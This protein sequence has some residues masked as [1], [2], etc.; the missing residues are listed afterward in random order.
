MNP[1]QGLALGSIPR[2]RRFFCPREK[3]ALF[4]STSRRAAIHKYIYFLPAGEAQE[5][6]SLRKLN[7]IKEGSTGPL[8]DLRARGSQKGA[9]YVRTR[10]H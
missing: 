6:S 8:L 2:R 3:N 10:T 7:G 1:F 9:L 4:S 5:L